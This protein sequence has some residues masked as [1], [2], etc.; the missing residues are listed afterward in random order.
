MKDESGKRVARSRLA[1]F[2]LY[3]PDL[4]REIKA[5]MKAES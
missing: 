1:V 2:S 4:T 3:V 5:R